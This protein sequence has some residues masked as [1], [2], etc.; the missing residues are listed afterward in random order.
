MNS[1]SSS[2][3]QQWYIRRSGVVRGPFTKEKITHYLLHG[4]LKRNDEFSLDQKRWQLVSELPK[5]LSSMLFKEGEAGLLRQQSMAEKP[6]EARQAEL[7][8]ESHHQQ[9]EQA[10]ADEFIEHESLISL[11][12][13]GSTAVNIERLGKGKQVSRPLVGFVIFSLLSVMIVMIYLNQP[14]PK[15]NVI[16][17]AGAAAPRVNWS[18]CQMEAA[19]LTGVNLTGA[20]MQNMN[21]MRVDLSGS[22]LVDANLSF[23]NLSVSD[24][25]GADLREATLVGV[26]FRGADLGGVVFDGAD[27]SYADLDGANISNAS[28]LGVKLDKTKWID[29]RLCAVGSIGHCQ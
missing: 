8:S 26:S 9:A 27:L 6:W 1:T 2:R 21:L 25:N 13:T 23:S 5:I 28:L 12:S 14:E 22:Q 16:D 15:A 17:C 11:D 18:N 24:L 10:A 29:G 19:L 7:N 3:H 20:T 4:R